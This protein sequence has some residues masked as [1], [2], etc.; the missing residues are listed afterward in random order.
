MNLFIYKIYQ[1][2]ILL[3][4]SLSNLLAFGLDIIYVLVLAIL[5]V[6]L[7]SSKNPIIILKD[8][9]TTSQ[10]LRIPTNHTLILFKKG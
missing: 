9:D 10:V 2:H 6:K 5:L 4:R 7:A 1:K 3:E 8:I